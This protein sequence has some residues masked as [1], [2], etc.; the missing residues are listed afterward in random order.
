[1]GLF[2]FVPWAL[3]YAIKNEGGIPHGTAAD[4]V[5]ENLK[6]KVRHSKEEKTLKHAAVYRKVHS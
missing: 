4:T 3:L 6:I 1:M 2:K 5:K